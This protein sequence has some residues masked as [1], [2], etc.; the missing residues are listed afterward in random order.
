MAITFPNRQTITYVPEDAAVT[1]TW[2]RNADGS[3]WHRFDICG[4]PCLAGEYAYE[5]TSD[6]LTPEYTVH[7]TAVR[8]FSTS[9]CAKGGGDDVQQ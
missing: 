7:T 4:T 5:V 6:T 1:A 9:V 2:G 8:T 3:Y